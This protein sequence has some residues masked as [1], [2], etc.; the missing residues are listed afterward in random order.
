[1]FNIIVAC[2]NNYYIINNL[3][4]CCSKY[5]EF[6]YNKIKNYN[7]IVN[8][9]T[10]EYLKDNNKMNNMII[11]DKS[12]N[13]SFNEVLQ[14]CDPN[15]K[16]YVIGDE[17]LYKE[18][19]I[20]PLLYK[21][22]ISKIEGSYNCDKYFPTELIASNKISLGKMLY[23]QPNFITYVYRNIN[24]YEIKYLE[25][26]ESLTNKILHNNRTQVMTYSS[27]GQSLKFKLYKYTFNDEIRILPLLTTKKVFYKSI[28]EELKF[29]IRGDTDTN[30]LLSSIWKGNTSQEFINSLGL[31]LK[32]G[33][34]GPM[35][36]YQWRYWGAEYGT[37]EPGIDQLTQVI[38]N[39]KKDP[40]NRRHIVSAWNVT[41]INKGVLAP[42][43]I[44]FQ[45]V[46]T[47]DK[48]DSQRLNCVM[49][50][51]SGDMFLGIPF[52]IASYALLT[53][54]ISDIV[55]IKPGKLVINIGDC[56]LYENHYY[57]AKEQIKRIP[58]GF[59]EV[60]FSKKILSIEDI[61]DTEVIISNYYHDDYIRAEMVV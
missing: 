3:L 48:Y 24:K 10:Y 33:E 6:F 19:I 39:I 7:I 4:L 23:N 30:K 55:D 26:L 50:Q 59:P 44:L 9:I 21:I 8:S 12:C 22:Y 13:T 53:H 51:R 28:I 5:L 41:D 14:K 27:V 17:T 25:L 37:D 58:R 49:T 47:L 11:I 31:N 20:H 16:T 52:N 38:N 45:F 36:G 40:Y 43:H 34:M 60:S 2:D 18:A 1:M 56:H 15:K 57:Q 54:F 46:I 61:E 35:Y 42:C 29:F 32:P